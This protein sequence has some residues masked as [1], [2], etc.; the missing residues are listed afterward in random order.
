MKKLQ[1]LFVILLCSA[2]SKEQSNS[3]KK[4]HIAGYWEIEQ[5]LFKGKKKE[6]SI[7][8]TVD[9]FYLE[10]ETSGYRKKVT[11]TIDGK[12]LGNENESTIELV[13]KNDS[14][15]ISY[16]NKIATWD[17][18]VKKADSSSMV[19]LNDRGLQYHYKRYE[20][21][22]LSNEKTN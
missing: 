8:N 16:K 22:D 15:F 9:L 10:N 3:D 19:L 12:F 1:V 2:C 7:S 11:P 5:V 4:K 14:L 13:T 17:E 6:Y 21:L 20:S 18:Y